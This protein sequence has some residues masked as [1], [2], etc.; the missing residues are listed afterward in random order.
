MGAALYDRMG[1]IRAPKSS[2]GQ[3]IGH[4][5]CVKV[6]QWDGVGN[7]VGSEMVYAVRIYW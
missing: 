6:Q 4:R 2:C 1:Y 3:G 7:C 5:G